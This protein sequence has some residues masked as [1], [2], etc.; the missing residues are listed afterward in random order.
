MMRDEIKRGPVMEYGHSTSLH[1]GDIVEF[2][3]ADKIVVMV[4][5]CRAVLSSVTKRK[6]SFTDARTGNDVSFT[7]VGS[8]RISVSPNSLIPVK[9]RLGKQG[10]EYWKANKELPA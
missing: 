10:L 2:D 5:E 7:S 4:N 6:V 8:D 3:G 9:R 1:P